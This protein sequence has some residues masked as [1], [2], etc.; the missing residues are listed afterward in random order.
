MNSVRMRMKAATATGGRD[1]LDLRSDLR[2]NRAARLAGAGS[3]FRVAKKAIA[4]MLEDEGYPELAARVLAMRIA[5][6]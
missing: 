2:E 6:R 1:G 4:K 5:R 3:G